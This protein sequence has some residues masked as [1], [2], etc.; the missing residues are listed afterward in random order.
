MIMRI[1]KK[2]QN[3]VFVVI[4]NI[5]YNK[6]GYDINWTREKEINEILKQTKN[7]LIIIITK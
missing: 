1:Q 2:N 5:N 6:Y 3:I 4:N 7:L